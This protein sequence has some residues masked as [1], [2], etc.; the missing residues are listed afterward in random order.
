MPFR[1]EAQRKWMFAA[2][3]RGEVPKG[4]AERWAH[5]TPKGKKLPEHVKKHKKTASELL[6]AVL[7][8]S[9]VMRDIYNGGNWAPGGV[10]YQGPMKL[11]ADP[12]DFAP[13]HIGPAAVDSGA[14]LA[15]LHAL[16]EGSP[17]QRLLRALGGAAEG[18]AIGG[19]AGALM[20]RFNVPKFESRGDLL[21]TGAGSIGGG[22]LGMLGAA[23][24]MSKRHMFHLPHEAWPYLFL[25][26]GLGSLGGS[27]LASEI[28]RRM[29]G[30]PVIEATR[31]TVEE[32]SMKK[33]ASEIADS[34][35]E[36][37]A[38]RGETVARA[39][40]K[41][42]KRGKVY[43]KTRARAEMLDEMPGGYEDS[44][45]VGNVL[46]GDPGASRL[47]GRLSKMKE[48]WREPHAESI[49]ALRRETASHDAARLKKK[50]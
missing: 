39:A 22:A 20:D 25:G 43:P 12:E 33:S 38:L 45:S 23:R 21:A 3:S 13:S 40:V 24:L 5:H 9:S 30:R 10:E 7:S 8:T 47:L 50:K 37:I 34:V 2:Q 4:T 44:P 31:Q 49:A 42:A 19:G 26:G 1:S 14:F 46:W 41:G 16:P 18:A 17:R 36:K 28:H 29:G 27:M 11:A 35:L 48:Q 15:M 6:D 32:G